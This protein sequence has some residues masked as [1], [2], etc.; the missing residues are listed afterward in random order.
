MQ[1]GQKGRDEVGDRW[2]GRVESEA[3]KARRKMRSSPND[4]NQAT[5]KW[6]AHVKFHLMTTLLSDGN[7]DPN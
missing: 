7:S 4:C 2:V 5:T 6:C 1:A 3:N